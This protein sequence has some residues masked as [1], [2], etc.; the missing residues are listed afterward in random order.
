M[1]ILV[2]G[3]KTEE[4]NESQLRKEQLQNK[5]LEEESNKQNLIAGLKTQL[6]VFKNENEVIKNEKFF[7]QRLCNDLKVA[8]KIHVNHNKALKEYVNG[9]C[10]ERGIYESMPVSLLNFPSPTKYDDVYINKLL[11]ENRAPLYD[12]PLNDIQECFN[13]LRKEI[14]I[15]QQQIV[16]KNEKSKY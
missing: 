2:F 9:I 16:E 7:L 10:K 5:W 11:Q 14:L 8:L 4:A 6:H 12:K 13:V 15:L 3:K 1:R